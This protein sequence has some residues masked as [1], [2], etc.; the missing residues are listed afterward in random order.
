LRLPLLDKNGVSEEGLVRE[1]SLNEL[2]PVA[3]VILALGSLQMGG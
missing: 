3:K 1:K 2:I